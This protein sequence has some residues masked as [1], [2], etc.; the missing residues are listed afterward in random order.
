MRENGGE[1][2]A[3]LRLVVVTPQGIAAQ[4]AC[5]S[6]V[7]PVAEAADGTP[8]G[9]VGV[10]RGHVPA[11]LAHSAG[12]VPSQCAMLCCARNLGPPPLSAI[13]FCPPLHPNAPRQCRP[14]L[15]MSLPIIEKERFLI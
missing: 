6:V 11:L 7:L 10:R 15:R 2:G 1:Q 5:D 4:A 12:T 3:P 9:T 13:G 8:G 14:A